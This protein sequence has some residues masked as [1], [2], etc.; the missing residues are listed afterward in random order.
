MSLYHRWHQAAVEADGEDVE[1]GHEVDGQR[2]IGLDFA[3]VSDQLWQQCVL[4]QDSQRNSD[5]AKGEPPAKTQY[6]LYDATV[7]RGQ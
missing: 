5:C 6:A 2:P 3:I 7:K 4:C 1:N